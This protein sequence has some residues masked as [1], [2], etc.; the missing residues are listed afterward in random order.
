MGLISEETK[1][2]LR[3]LVKKREELKKKKN[4]CLLDNM[5]KLGEIANISIK[6]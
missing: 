2:T 3:N 1:E 6:K 5:K 4:Q